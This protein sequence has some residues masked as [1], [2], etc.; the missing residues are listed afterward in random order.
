M[1]SK[2]FLG[3][4]FLLILLH[5]PGVLSSQ[6][7]SGGGGSFYFGT[8]SPNSIEAVSQLSEAYRITE[9]GGWRD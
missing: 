6:S 8:G 7:F 5:I 3:I 9:E 1:T 4:A 2:P